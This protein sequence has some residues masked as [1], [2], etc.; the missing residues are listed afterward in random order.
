MDF[1]HFIFL[2]SRRL[3]PKKKDLPLTP[4]GAGAGE[5]Q[6]FST[7]PVPA[8]FSTSHRFRDQPLEF[9]PGGLQFA[10]QL[11][12]SAGGELMLLGDFSGRFPH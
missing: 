4:T 10:T 12:D 11:G 5:D 1:A 6:G 8:R 3:I 9:I 2:R 7:G